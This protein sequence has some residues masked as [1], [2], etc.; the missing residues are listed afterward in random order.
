MTRELWVWVQAVI[1]LVLNHCPCVN[2]SGFLKANQFNTTLKVSE[3]DSRLLLREHSLPL[4]LESIPQIH[5]PHTN[6]TCESTQLCENA[7]EEGDL[8]VKEAGKEGRGFQ[9]RTGSL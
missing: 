6:L 8:H 1:L 9:R 4:P 2:S 3:A 7:A 5:S